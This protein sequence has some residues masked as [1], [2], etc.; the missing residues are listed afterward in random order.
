MNNIFVEASCLLSLLTHVLKVTAPVTQPP[1]NLDWN[2]IYYL[3]KA[4]S[5]TNAVF[6]ALK[7]QN[8]NQLPVDI[9]MKFSNEHEKEVFKEAQQEVES[10]QIIAKLTENKI[11][12]MPLKGFILKNLYAKPDIRSMTDIDMLVDADKLDQIKEIMLQLGFTLDH[13]YDNHD[14][15]FKPPFMTVEFH[16]ALIAQNPDMGIY[17]YF[18][19]WDRSKLKTG[20]EYVYELTN[21]DYYIYMIGHMAKHFY[22]GGC[23]IRSVMDIWVYLDYYKNSLDFVYIKTELEK[24]NYNGRR[25]DYC[26]VVGKARRH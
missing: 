4:H 19:S 12:C 8:I 24:C 7:K 13:V 6:Y 15:Y 1:E 25:Y 10:N 5:I 22:S 26:A 14:V 20:S 18:G 3:S 11:R 17:E 9:A 2:N 16:R 23:G 21:E